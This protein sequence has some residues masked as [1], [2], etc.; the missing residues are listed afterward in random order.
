LGA[1]APD[2]WVGVGHQRLVFEVHQ[3]HKSK[4]AITSN[5]AIARLSEAQLGLPQTMR[6]LA[7]ECLMCRAWAVTRLSA[8]Y[9][10]PFMRIIRLYQPRNPLFWIMVV[11]NVLSAVLG[12]LTHTHPL[13]AL[14]SVLI[15]GFAT[16]NTVLGTWLA[17][18]LMNS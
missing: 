4:K 6:T 18:R 17:W 3:G 16:G 10:F 1:D 9:N 8:N 14:V 5:W 12:W 15:I 13:G 2:T 11:L 7:F